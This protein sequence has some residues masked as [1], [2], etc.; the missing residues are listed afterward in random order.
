[1]GEYD[2]V[3]VAELPSDDAVAK[4]ALSLG[5]AGNIRTRTSRAF[6]EAEYRKLIQSLP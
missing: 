6:T 3:V 4:L 2:I 1:M 5:A